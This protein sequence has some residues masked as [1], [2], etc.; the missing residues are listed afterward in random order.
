MHC[1]KDLDDQ[2]QKLQDA[3]LK[4]DED[5]IVINGKKAQI[6]QLQQEKGDLVAFKQDMMRVA[7]ERQKAME[8]VSAF[9]AAISVTEVWHTS[10]FL[11]VNFQAFLVLLMGHNFGVCLQKNEAEAYS[12]LA[13]KQPQHAAHHNG[14]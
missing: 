8:S 13:R 14:Q 6:V 4:H 11:L 5:E 7:G 10:M 3:Q 1:R 9:Q 12:K 2:T